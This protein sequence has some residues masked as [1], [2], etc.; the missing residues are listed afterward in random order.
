MADP[1]LPSKDRQLAALDLGSNSFHLLVAQENNGRIQVIDK[2]KETVRLAEGLLEG[3]ELTSEVMERALDCLNRFSQR[4]RGLQ[5]HD[6]RVVGTNTLRR[7]RNS[8]K[9]LQ[10][11]EQILNSKV[12][13]ISG[14]EEARLI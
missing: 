13:V 12:E 11:V 1:P 3:D 8:K 6:V 2:I 5:P 14:R 9:F 7:A 10:D 4:L